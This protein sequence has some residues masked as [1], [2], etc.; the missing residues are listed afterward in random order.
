MVRLTDS[1]EFNAPIN[2]IASNVIYTASASTSIKGLTFVPQQ[3]AHTAELIP[4]P[5]LLPQN[6]ASVSGTFTVTN[7][8]DDPLWRTNITGITVNGTAL[9]SAAYDLTQAG[10]IVFDPSQSAL[11]Q[12]PGSKTIV[13]SAAGYSTNS[14]TSRR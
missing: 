2:I 14:I 8:P 11:L 7:S 12:S 3:T 6:A 4:P 1:G 13:I 10:K 5:V 9:P